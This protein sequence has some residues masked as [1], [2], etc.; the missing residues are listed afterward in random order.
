MWAPAEEGGGTTAPAEPATP[1]E[2]DAP[3]PAPAPA[4]AD[5]VATPAPAPVASL[6]SGEPAVKDG[7]GGTPEGEAAEPLTA[8]SFTFPEGVEP[9][10]GSV[11]SFLEIMNAPDLS[12]AE[13]AQ[14]LV[15]YQVTSQTTA[16]EAAEAAATSMWDE[17]QSQWQKDAS[18]LPE[19]GGAA[20]PQTLATIKKGLTA[21]GATPETFQALDLTGAG[22]H[23]EMVKILHSLTKRYAEQA[24]VAG[25]PPEG[26]LSQADR[27]FAG[28]A[29]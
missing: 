1:V 26:K 19:I 18:A 16:N 15:D 11:A 5:P 13:L 23:P 24:P 21:A 28:R 10:A 14:K 17:A 4:P 8:E 27:M 7:E 2:G 12:R 25:S 22:N 3:A 6:V 20:L 29:D 9:D